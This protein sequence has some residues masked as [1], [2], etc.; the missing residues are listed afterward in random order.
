ME[1]VSDVRH[2]DE[3]L[4]KHSYSSPKTTA[5]DINV[6]SKPKTVIKE[7]CSSPCPTET[8][9]DTKKQFVNFQR[10]VVVEP[11]SKPVFEHDSKVDQKVGTE[12]WN[13]ISQMKL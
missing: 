6:C 8:Y 10:T 7:K 2:E 12:L 11:S 1:Y 3:E 4:F 13:D 5:K 9:S